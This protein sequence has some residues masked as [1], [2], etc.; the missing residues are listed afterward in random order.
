MARAKR[1]MKGKVKSWSD[2]KDLNQ[3]K[4][5]VE[6]KQFSFIVNKFDKED[7]TW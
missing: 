3:K 2:F 7:W 6:S 5:T 4:Q 1:Q